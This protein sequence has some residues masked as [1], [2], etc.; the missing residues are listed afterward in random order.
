MRS[1]GRLV[2]TL[3]K[4]GYLTVDRGRYELTPHVL[5]LS[6]GFIEGRG[7]TQVIQPIL[8]NAA[9]EIGEAVSFA[10]LDDI[11]GVY[12]AHAFLPEGFTLNR[13]AVG[14][15]LPLPQTAAG[16]AILAFLDAPRRDRILAG[17]DFA[18]FAE[19][20]GTTRTR[21]DE[22]LRVTRDRGYG[23]S[24]SDYVSDVASLAV[25]VFAPGMGSVTGAVSIIFEHGRYDAAQ[26]EKIVS[27]LKTCAT[28]VASTL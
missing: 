22:M 15:R 27:C 11:D 28:H 9:E 1:C 19:R 17:A 12:V 25:P 6:Q 23:E 26:R 16:R 8:R 4:L 7:I 14:T 20:T 13:V 18:A 24:D 3:E 10:M 21:F 5:R 2:R